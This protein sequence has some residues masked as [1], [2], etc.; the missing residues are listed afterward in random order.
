MK[1]VNNNRGMTLIEITV[2]LLISTILLTTVGSILVSSLNFFRDQ[3]ISDQNKQKL[4]GI[5]EYVDSEINYATDVAIS[6]NNFL[7]GKYVEQGWHYLSIIDGKLYRDGNQV[8]NDSYYDNYI[9]NI[10]VNGYDKYHLDVQYNFS[11]NDDVNEVVYDTSKSYVFDNVKLKIESG[12][13]DY[14]TNKS[15]PITE[16]GNTIKRLYYKKGILAVVDP[17]NESDDGII[18]VGDQIKC[19]NPLNNHGQF[20]EGFYYM[21]GDMVY[22]NGYWWQYINPEGYNGGTPGN[23]VFRDWKKISDE[24]DYSSGYV[25]GDIVFNKKGIKFICIN[26][27]SSGGYFELNGK[28]I[29]LGEEVDQYNKA[30]WKNWF[31]EYEPGDEEGRVHNCEDLWK[32]NQP[33]VANELKDY[34]DETVANI[35]EYDATQQ[36]QVGDI[37]KKLYPGSDKY[38]YYCKKEFDGDGEPGSSPESGWKI[39]ERYYNPNSSYKTGDIVFYGHHAIGYIVATEDINFINDPRENVNQNINWKRYP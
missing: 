1:Q 35:K 34:K 20:V 7:D 15:G 10:D 26:N 2:V 4:D 27:F 6:D 37:V 38:Y 9:V 17:G 3:K 14:L 30:P 11:H 12:G 19:L 22:C 33:T 24:F 28:Y 36:Y 21:H 32:N 39:L 23:R 31:K 16:V 5:A 8:F 25:V 13:Q 18:T 29:E